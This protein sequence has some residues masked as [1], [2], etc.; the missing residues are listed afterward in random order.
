[1]EAAKAALTR[2]FASLY[3]D[4]HGDG[5][6]YVFAN[7]DDYA[8]RISFATGARSSYRGTGVP[9]GWSHDPELDS[10]WRAVV[11]TGPTGESVNGH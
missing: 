4:P 2:R 7:Q 8:F 1:M 11:F 10:A 9:N 3:L 6:Q 5:T